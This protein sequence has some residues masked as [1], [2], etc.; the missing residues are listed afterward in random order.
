MNNSFLYIASYLL[1]LTQI[2]SMVELNIGNG[3]TIE[4]IGEMNIEFS[5]DIEEN[6]TGY[7]KRTVTEI[8]INA[9]DWVLIELRNSTTP[10]SIESARSVLFKK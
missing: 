3:L 4:T 10:S 9:V 5:G 7:L 1:L 8:P 6:T 2:F